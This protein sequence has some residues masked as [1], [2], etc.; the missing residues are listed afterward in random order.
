MSKKWED[1]PNKFRYL[2]PGY[3]DFKKDQEKK[4]N[5]DHNWQPQYSNEPPIN[6]E[7]AIPLESL[8][9]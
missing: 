2:D 5:A 3:T 1:C 8:L 6:R 7:Y 4:L 9:I